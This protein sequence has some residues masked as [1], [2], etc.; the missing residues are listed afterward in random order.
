MNALTASTY[1]DVYDR[2][3]A[4]LPALLCL[5]AVLG[6]AASLAHAWPA[7]AL[8]RRRLRRCR[9]SAKRRV[10]TSSAPIAIRAT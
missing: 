3:A 8:A 6:L 5:A 9:E 1:N 10:C 4:V 2:I 7:A